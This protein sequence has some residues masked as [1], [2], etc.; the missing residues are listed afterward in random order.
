MKD[1]RLGWIAGGA[2]AL[3]LVGVAI[4]IVAELTAGDRDRPLFSPEWELC[5]RADICVAV[6]A[7][8]GEWQPVN[9]KYE[10]D[11]AAYYAHLIAVVESEMICMSRNLNPRKPQALCIS[12]VCGLAQ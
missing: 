4:Y 7:P 9:E 8:C 1:G 5:D 12:G 6:P 2:G 10:Q 3:L 11:A